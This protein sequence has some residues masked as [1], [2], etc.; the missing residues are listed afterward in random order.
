MPGSDKKSSVLVGDE[1]FAK[2]SPLQQ[3]I[4]LEL[5]SGPLCLNELSKKT[6][7]SIYTV[8]KQLSLLEFRAKYNPLEKKGIYGP[9]VGKNK[10]AK[11][12]T[13]YFL[14]NANPNLKKS[15]IRIMVLFFQ[16]ALFYF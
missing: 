2:L 5:S 1:V 12:K 7:S 9:L 3:K 10:D 6:G 14:R 11:I 15:L 16:G 8:G 13:T 4:L